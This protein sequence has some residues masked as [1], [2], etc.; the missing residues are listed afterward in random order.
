MEASAPRSPVP[1]LAAG[2]SLVTLSQVVTAVAGAAMSVAI[3]RLLGAAG[4]GAFNLIQSATLLG[5]AFSSLGIEVGIAYLVASGRWPAWQA[6]RQSALA[7]VA[8]GIVGGGVA[9]AII[10]MAAESAFEGI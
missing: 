3:A 1:P 6:L 2:A 4:T 5:G 9:Y 8:L 7:A 10:V